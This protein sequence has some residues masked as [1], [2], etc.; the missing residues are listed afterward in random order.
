[1]T[2]ND[3]ANL[4]RRL[5][6]KHLGPIP[7]V[8]EA[9]AE[10]VRLVLRSIPDTTTLSYRNCEMALALHNIELSRRQLR[11]FREDEIMRRMG[12]AQREMIARRE[13]GA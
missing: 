11:A 1:M 9:T 8:D 4:V 7:E 12:E 13:G 3:D 6:Y 5:A 10:R 2:Y